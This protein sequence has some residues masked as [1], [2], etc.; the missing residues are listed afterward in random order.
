MPYSLK[1]FTLLAGDLVL[2][3]TAL[4][5]TLILRYQGS[6]TWE[7]WNQHFLPFTL[8][9][10]F[11]V[12]VFYINDLYEVAASKNDVEFY[13][14]L[15]KNLFINFATAAVYFYLLTDKLFD[16][17]P[18][19]V[20]FVFMI[21][22][23][24]LFTLW[25]FWYNSLVQHPGFLKNVLVVGMKDEAR[26][27]IEEIIKKPQL[28]YR[29]SAVI[30]DGYQENA[31]FPGVKAFNSSVN[32]KKILREEQIS[33]VVTALDPR[34]EPELLKHLYESLSLKIQFM[35]LP[36]FYEKLTGKI[37]I[38][39]I[40]H[41]WFL[42]NLAENEN[43]LYE[44]G[45]RILDLTLSGITL[46]TSI[47]FWPLIAMLVKLDSP[48]AI[49]FRQKRIGQHGKEFQVIKFRSMIVGAEEEGLAKWAQKNDPRITR[50]GKFLRKSRLD[51]LPQL[52]NIIK[53]E[54]SIAGPRPERPEFVEKLEQ[55][56]PFYNQRHL[57]KP[58]LTGWAQINFQYGASTRDAFKKLQYDLFY[59]KNRSLP[60]DI[61][62]ILKTIN[63][64]IRGK[65]Q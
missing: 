42:E 16:I 47:L 50:I 14:K 18:K 19:A 38:T 55:E 35:D 30:H 20:F 65:G 4:Y 54:M 63:I 62:I 26:E 2:L 36:L 49:F 32:I 24:A 60:L 53:G 31:K 33:L 27:L 5:L 51:E 61:G 48:G 8:L 22:Y 23:V 41:I 1:R 29:I 15:L 34:T 40:G 58:G 12:A 64:M 52:L 11:W 9:F 43:Y 13:N 56:I 17:K 59:I 37:P 25:R 44:Y 3:Y 6:L 28:G 45:K 57:V 46:L 7:I 10:F 39:T 21:I